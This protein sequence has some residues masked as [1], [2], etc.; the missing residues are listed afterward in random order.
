M[1]KKFY[2]FDFESNNSKEAIE[3][4]ETNVWLWDIYDVYIDKHLNGNSIESFFET[5]SKLK[6]SILYAHNL[7]F[8]GN[9]IIAYLLNNNYTWVENKPSQNQFTTLI[10]DM[11]Q[12]YSIK[13]NN[14]AGVIEF[15]DSLKKIDGSVEEMAY[16]YDLPIKKGS[17][18]YVL[19]RPNGYIPTEEEYEYIWN[20]TEIVAKVLKFY[21][22]V[23]I[24]Q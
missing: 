23:S 6:S 18:D 15:R 13:Y 20:D 12:F 14:G 8:D 10:S 7:K 22:S 21:Y 9:F 5:L 19:D 16:A 3:R 4:G 1:N 17:I 2:V 24:K 11:G